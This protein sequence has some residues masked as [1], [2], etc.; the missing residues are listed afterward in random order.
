M[1][2]DAGPEGQVVAGGTDLFPNMKRRQ[3]TPKTV[4][5]LRR[6]PELRRIS[7][8]VIGACVTLTEVCERMTLYPSL[9][10]AC[11]LVATPLIQNMATIGGNLCLDTRC[12]Y[13]DQ[14]YEWRK[15]IDFCKKKDGAVCW[16]APGSP[17]C[18]AVASSDTAPLLIAMGAKVK[19]VSP[20]GERVIDLEALYNDDGIA[21]LTKR[22]DE[23][24]A[25]VHLPPANGWRAT[26]RKLRRRGSFDF[27]VLGVGAWI[28]FGRDRFVEDARIALTGV[29]SRPM[30]VSEAAAALKGRTLT[31]E[32]IAAAAHASFVRGKPLDNTDLNMTWRKEMIRKWVTEALR[33]LSRQAV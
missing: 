19:L 26:Y 23:I 11:S 3:Q 30:L 22:P 21:Y 5:G 15:A 2:A 12:N 14:T 6:I 27:P 10:Q 29:G 24:L 32:T 4:I 8:T 1:L 28:R 20:T 13:Y 18:W 31:E 16:V 25:E 7:E 17:R 9:Q 33:D